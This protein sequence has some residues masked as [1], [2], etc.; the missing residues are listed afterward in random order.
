MRTVLILLTLTACH[1]EHDVPPLTLGHA[2]APPDIGVT[3]GMTESDAREA[4]PAMHE[5]TFGI[6]EVERDGRTLSMHIGFDKRVVGLALQW[7]SR[8]CLDEVTHAWGPPNAQYRDLP[9]T[10]PMPMWSGGAWEAHLDDRIVCDL[11]FN[12][13]GANE[14]LLRSLGSVTD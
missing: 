10:R 3:V 14:K 6:V 12:E 1:R 2:I 9:G 5:G 7:E 4:C 13:R 11:L 8:A